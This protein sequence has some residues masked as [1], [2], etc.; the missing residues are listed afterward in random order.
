MRDIRL[1]RSGELA[2]QRVVAAEAAG[3]AAVHVYD[4]ATLEGLADCLL[5]LR[6]GDS[7]D[8]LGE[9]DGGTFEEGEQLGGVLKAQRGVL[10]VC[11]ELD[12]EQVLGVVQLLLGDVGEGP[13]L[14]DCR[15]DHLF[16]LSGTRRTCATDPETLTPNRPES[17]K[18][19]LKGSAETT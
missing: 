4:W 11:V 7:V 10:Q 3:V 13:Q 2:G 16:A 19:C 5:D 1:E 14:L 17:L 9:V 18:E 15:L 6:N 12:L 8:V